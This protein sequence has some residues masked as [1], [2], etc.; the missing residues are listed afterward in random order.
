MKILGVNFDELSELGSTPVDL[1]SFPSLL[2]YFKASANLDLSGAKPIPAHWERLNYSVGGEP[3]RV[4]HAPVRG[5]EDCIYVVLGKKDLIEENV[6]NIRHANKLGKSVIVLEL[7]DYGKEIGDMGFLRELG[8]HFRISNI[9]LFDTYTRH[10]N[11]SHSTGGYLEMELMMDDGAS[12]ELCRRSESSTF[13]APYTTAS[14]AQSTLK[15]W[16]FNVRAGLYPDS[17][18]GETRADRLYARFQEMRGQPPAAPPERN[19]TPEQVQYMQ[20]QC[21]PLVE[22]IK[23]DGFPEHVKDRPSLVVI[24]GNDFVSDP[25]ASHIIADSMGAQKS[26][27]PNGWHRPHVERST[28]RRAIFGHIDEAAE[29]AARRNLQSSRA[30]ADAP[31][32]HESFSHLNDLALANL[33]FSL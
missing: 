31:T 24:G 9:P 13:V 30:D 29:N 16:A 10:H 21:S 26:F 2:S 5:A 11:M 23:Q 19:L 18:Y 27:H 1:P 14:F 15:T 12:R 8:E 32:A 20:D 25:G 17:R 3:L 28:A 22:R 4:L 7:P 6:S 33:G